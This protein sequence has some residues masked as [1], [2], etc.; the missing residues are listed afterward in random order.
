M[1]HNKI[2]SNAII[3]IR[4]QAANLEYNGVTTKLVEHCDTIEDELDKPFKHMDISEY[5]ESDIM[6]LEEFT[7]YNISTL[8]QLW[9]DLRNSISVDEADKHSY[10]G[11]VQSIYSTKDRESSIFAELLWEE[12]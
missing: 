9:S 12:M 10:R 1:R 6:T 7:N 5:T 3:A 8:L 11:F 4:L 2:I